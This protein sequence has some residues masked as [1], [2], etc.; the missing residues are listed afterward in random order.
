MHFWVSKSACCR[1]CVPYPTIKQTGIRTIQ[2]LSYS[3]LL[4]C[5]LFFIIFCVAGLANIFWRVA[6]FSRMPK[7]GQKVVSFPQPWRLGWNQWIIYTT[8]S[9]NGGRRCIQYSSGYRR[10][11]ATFT[12]RLLGNNPQSQSKSDKRY[13]DDDEDYDDD[14]EVDQ[15]PHS[16]NFESDDG[17]LPFDESQ[18]Q[19]T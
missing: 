5:L 3:L 1:Q 16:N 13:L 14:E 11:P 9:G 4:F 18:Q 12:R 7:E 6:A 15:K 2:L 8:S 17:D 19:V 10:S